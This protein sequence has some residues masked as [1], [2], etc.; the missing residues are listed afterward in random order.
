M[1][2]CGEHGSEIVYEGSYCPACDQI[3]HLRSEFESDISHLESDIAAL[4]EQLA[5]AR[6]EG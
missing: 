5:E 3:D 4:E 1:S 2:I 6:D